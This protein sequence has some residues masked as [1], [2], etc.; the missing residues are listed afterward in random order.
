MLLPTAYFLDVNDLNILKAM[1]H[2]GN[3]WKYKFEI[4]SHISFI[5]RPM[6]KQRH[7]LFPV[8]NNSISFS[9][10]VAFQLFAVVF[11]LENKCSH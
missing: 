11:I 8:E 5:I 4:T 2:L 1:L 10:A 3:S 7:S 6:G 9:T